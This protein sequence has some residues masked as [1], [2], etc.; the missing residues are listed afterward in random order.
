MP[1]N[2]KVEFDKT[3]FAD[4]STSASTLYIVA[5]FMEKGRALSLDSLPD[6]LSMYLLGF[7]TVRDWC[8]L[9]TVSRHFF[10]VASDQALWKRRAHVVKSLG[11][12]SRVCHSSVTCKGEM[13]VYGGHNPS[14]GSNFIADV[15][16]ELFIYNIGAPI[17]ICCPH[18]L[19]HRSVRKDGVESDSNPTELSLSY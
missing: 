1:P 11:P 6:E 12:T 3:A 7:L 2:G 8:R 9:S 16:N 18:F 5:N 10:R 17:N 4:H 13:F 19:S 15:K 14:P